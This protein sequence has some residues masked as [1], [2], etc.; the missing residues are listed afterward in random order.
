[1]SVVVSVVIGHGVAEDVAEI[2]RVVWMKGAGDG[3][4]AAGDDGDADGSLMNVESRCI[5]PVALTRIPLAPS[6]LLIT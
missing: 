6:K 2:S 5:S 4:S 1:M 3:R